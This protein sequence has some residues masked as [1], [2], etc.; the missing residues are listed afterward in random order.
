MCLI[1][2]QAFLAQ[3][4]RSSVCFSLKYMYFVQWKLG[5]S[6]VHYV[7]W[8]NPITLTGDALQ[9]LQHH[10]NLPLISFTVTPHPDTHC[11]SSSN[12]KWFPLHFLVFSL[13]TVCVCVEREKEK[14]REIGVE[15]LWKVWDNFLQDFNWDIKPPFGYEKWRGKCVLKLGCW[16]NVLEPE[17]HCSVLLSPHFS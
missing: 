16:L 8:L 6:K 13:E 3:S 4:L 2:V 10:K 5:V 11:Q 17:D 14:E 15:A 7:S 1:S 12:V 9:S